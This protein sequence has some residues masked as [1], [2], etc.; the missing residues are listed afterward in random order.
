M[1][2]RQSLNHLIPNLSNDDLVLLAR[3]GRRLLKPNPEDFRRKLSELT[4]TE[5]MGRSTLG[6]EPILSQVKTKPI[7]SPPRRRCFPILPGLNPYALLESRQRTRLS[8]S[9]AVD[10][11]V[12]S[13]CLSFEGGVIPTEVVF[14]EQEL[15]CGMS[16]G[17]IEETAK[18]SPLPALHALYLLSSEIEKTLRG[19]RS[20]F[21]TK[22]RWRRI[23][24]PSLIISVGWNDDRQEWNLTH[25]TKKLPQ[26]S[27]V[28]SGMV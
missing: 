23:V 9:I 21:F 26:G 17:D 19:E 27:M 4:D 14:L 25:G 18:L 7:L 2:G 13:S 22:G 16:E 11:F 12:R 6:D 20:S 10:P 3:I 1:A 5:A 28:A 24:A 15:L 8:D